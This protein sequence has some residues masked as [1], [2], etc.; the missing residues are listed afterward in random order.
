MS[1]QLENWTSNPDETHGP[2]MSVATWVLCGVRNSGRGFDHSIGIPRWTGP[3][4]DELDVSQAASF[5]ADVAD[6]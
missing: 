1:S 4:S 6:A 3:G 2:L 5:G